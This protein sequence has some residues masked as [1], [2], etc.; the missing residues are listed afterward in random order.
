VND[1]RKT[2]S[3]LIAELEEMRQRVSELE[4]SK[5][6]KLPAELA[7]KKAEKILFNSED[8]FRNF[9][10]AS[11]DLFVRLNK[12]GFIEYISPRVKDLYGYEVDELVGKHLKKT[13]P[14]KEVPKALSALKSVFKG[15]TLTNFQINQVAKSGK[16]I[17]MEINAIPVEKNGNIIGFQ[18]VLRDITNRKQREEN[19]HENENLLLKIAENYPNSFLSI[20]EKDFTIG[21]TSGQEFKK[22]NLDPE[23]FIGLNL[24]QVFG[25]KSAFVREYYNKTFKGEEQSFELFI[26]DQ[27]QLF[28]TVPL[29]SED[30]S[31]TRILAA[32]ENI[33]ERKQAEKALLESEANMAAI[34]ENTLDSI[35][36]I[37][38]QYEIL[39][40]NKVFD[41]SFQAT[42][43][44]KLVPGSNLLQSL[45]KAI[46]PIWKER[47]DRAFGGERYVF[48]DQVEVG[49]FIIHI[50]VAVNPIESEGQVVGAS[51]FG[52]DITERKQGEEELQKLAA[53]VKHS[54][55]LVNL[56]TMEGKM[57][58][59]NEAG[60]RML[61][62]NPQEVEHLNIIE[63]IPEHLQDLVRSELLPTLMRGN[64]WEGDLQY[65][66]LQT[67]RLTDV[68]AMTF[69]VKDPDTQKPLFLANVSLDITQ[70]KQAEE[71]ITKSEEKYRYFFENSPLG[72][73]SFND[74]GDILEVNENML[75]I[76]GSP[77]AEATKQ[78]NVI[79][80]PPLVDVGFTK[81]YKQC[82]ETGNLIET[83][84]KYTSKWKKNVNIHCLLSPIHDPDNKIV[85]VYGIFEDITERKQVEEALRES[86]R[87]FRVLTESSP[88][89][90]YY[91]NLNGTFV[92]GNKKA[93]EITGY[94]RGELIGNNFLKLKL[95]N[96]K[97]AIK[98]AKLLAFN[99]LGKSTGPDF[100][101]INRKDSTQKQ[102]EISTVIINIGLDKVVMGMVHDI[103][104]R[105]RS[106]EALQES[107]DKFRSIIDQSTESI[108]MIDSQGL[109][110]EW[111][112]NQ[113][114]TAGITRSQALGKPIWKLMPKTA[115]TDAQSQKQLT[116][117][118]RK[119]Q[120][121]LKSGEFSTITG[122]DEVQYTL[123]DGSKRYVEHYYFPVKTK[124]Q[125]YLANITRDI[126]ERKQADKALEES[127]RRFRSTVESS[128]M[129][130]HFYQLTEKN[131][132]VF[133]GAN[134]TADSILNVDNSIFIGKTIE[135][136]FPPLVKTEIPSKYKQVALTGEI[137]KT[138]Q[139]EY[140]DHDIKGAFEVVAFQ[141][142]PNKMVSLFNE[143]TEKMKARVALKESEEKFR[144][145]IEQ[146]NDAIY[147]LLDDKFEIINSR[148]TEIFGYSLKECQTENFNF[149]KLIAPKSLSLV[150]NRIAQYKKGKK[151]K[152]MYE[153]TAISKDGKEIECEVST[154]HIEYKG[155]IAVQGII[156]NITNRKQAEAEKAKLEEQLR[157][158]Q[159]LETIGTL[160]GGIAHDFNNILAPIMGYTDMALLKLEKTNPLYDDLQHVLKGA[161][162][163]KELVEQILLFSKQS[164]K[165]RKPLA[166]KS[167][168]R[169]ALKLLRPSIPTTIEIKQYIDSK[170]AKIQADATQMHQVIVNLCTNAWQAMEE[171]GGIL[172]IELIELEL[173]KTIAKLYPNLNKDKY[174]RL[175]ISDTG[176]G[177]DKNTLER[178]F[179]PFFTTKAVNKGTGLGLSVVHG[180]VSSHKGDIHVISKPGKGSVFHVYLPT[181]ISED[182]LTSEKTTEIAKGSEYVLVVD[183]ET[184][185]GNLI[186]KILENFGYK[187]EV[188]NSGLTAFEVF[189][190]NPNKFDLLIT[191]LT[192]PQMTGLDLA[193]QIHRIK[194]KLP[195]LIMTGFGDSITSATQKRY[196]IKQVLGKPVVIEDLT[197]AIR[198]VLDR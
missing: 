35:W 157:R 142:E 33:T 82:I 83:D 174:L 111:N 26:N 86:E 110:V 171:D 6:W 46:R 183:D 126:T 9:V 181:I 79:N 106:E 122:R 173:D 184:A 104:E 114:Q 170:C 58:F 14:L 77:S 49:S 118:I 51:F 20:I 23:Q 73:T 149:R 159:K 84:F 102:V 89:G 68:H 195:V 108:S 177:M 17:P 138:E 39:Y 11:N 125:T 80:Y 37:N 105:K 194:P 140:E 163:A 185:I 59:L 72:I 155:G 164:E 167:L 64:I 63:V 189:K 90:I 100:F 130:M 48:V 99:K 187:T 3:Q 153:F 66:N 135:E 182:T 186:K 47:Y 117:G 92:Y 148:F 25:D 41:Q 166:I 154:S 95:L 36:A 123:K 15:E 141:T 34:I 176:P 136:A 120:E 152:P 93:E 27:Y 150:E 85:G 2:K 158:A 8:M 151:L 57:V 81:Y 74:K 54:S 1:N 78:I 107:E 116:K 75:K 19:L 88:I 196:G 132:L 43:G 60:S 96:K 146:S 94:K 191:D 143:I 197:S 55:E 52:R 98:A 16:I 137:W 193:D 97:D 45:P 67:G 129:G 179:E 30:G 24:E 188:F 7:G 4:Q 42:F 5:T 147:S 44:V 21:F 178:I 56:A 109:V 38:T 91:V 103:T 112:R 124:K 128:P 133:T 40:T 18:G 165:E 127:E 134:P 61:G 70:R 13:T 198:N 28:R 161:H 87:K 10:E 144:T 29:Y 160:A 190:E 119:I 12:K 62:I 162:R 145:L 71:S 32:V 65:K 76:L 22:Q 113:E 172:T 131:Q 156:R 69:T 168:V 169:E 180:I 50:E 192:M 121:L 115:G 139:I 31:I 53:V 175:S 101:T